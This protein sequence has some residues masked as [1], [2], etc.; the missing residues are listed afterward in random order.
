MNKRARY[1]EQIKRGLT[2]L[3][4]EIEYLNNINLTHYNIIAEYFYRDLLVFYGFELNN[5]N[6]KQKNADSIDLVDCK[7]KIAIQV[8]SRNDTTKIHKTIKGFY[9]NPEY[10]EFKR[11]I[12]LLIG[13]PKLDYPKTDF[14]QGNLFSFNKETDIIDV[15]D[16]IKK[17]GSFTAKEQEPIV[18]FLENEIDLKINTKRNL[19]DE[20]V[21]IIRLIEYLSDENNL[22]IEE[23]KGEHIDPEFKIRKRFSEYSANLENWYQD[24]VSHYSDSLNIAKNTI[25][26]DGVKVK[27]I[28]SFLK[29]ISDRFLFKSD[30]NPRLALDNLIDYFE[31][32][33]PNCHRVAIK[34]Y[35]LDELIQCNVFPN[36]ID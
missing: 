25:G 3:R 18:D 34:F 24:L 36:P 7:N 10:D 11:L 16:I 29:D 2:I 19:S 35:L 23:D 13:K 15:D 33:I 12:M 14:S 1:T 20:V 8:T 30:N 26:I 4:Y 22:V 31:E 32:K 5:L 6:E 27:I 28:N 17:F 21:T 9:N